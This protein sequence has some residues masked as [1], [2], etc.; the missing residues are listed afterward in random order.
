MSLQ[1]Q[2]NISSCSV[3]ILNI[4][5]K[6]CPI[7]LFG[8]LASENSAKDNFKW[9]VIFL[10]VDYVLPMYR[11]GYLHRKWKWRSWSFKICTSLW[12]Q[13]VYVTW[14]QH[15][16]FAN[17]RI[18]SD[19]VIYEESDTVTWKKRPSKHTYFLCS[20]ANGSIHNLYKTVVKKSL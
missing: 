18:I 15:I 20:L 12:R 9:T 1:S 8:K 5:E 7:C 4:L 13:I 2:S 16:N 14:D 17:E 19:T 11:M 3:R 10:Q 6:W